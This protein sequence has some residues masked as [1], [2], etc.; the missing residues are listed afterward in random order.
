M[1]ARC[2]ASYISFKLKSL[3]CTRNYEIKYQHL[4]KNSK[5]TVAA[6]QS[7]ETLHW[8]SMLDCLAKG[9]LM[10]VNS[11]TMQTVSWL[12]KWKMHTAAWSTRARIKSSVYQFLMNTY[13]TFVQVLIHNMV[14]YVS[15]QLQLLVII[16]FF[17]WSDIR[18][19]NDDIYPC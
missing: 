3:L 9:D 19:K 12:S 17:L 15:L 10:K 18:K 6:W 14:L 8:M 2:A 13:K 5:S 1:T 7:N 4:G 16:Q 11:S